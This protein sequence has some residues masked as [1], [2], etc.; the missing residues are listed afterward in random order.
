MRYDDGFVAYLNGREIARTNARIETHTDEIVTSS[1]RCAEE[2]AV[3][4]ARFDVSQ[5][6]TAL[7]SGQNVLAIKVL[8]ARPSSG[9]YLLDPRL[10]IDYQP[11]ARLRKP[12]TIYYTVD[13]PDPRQP[14]G[15]VHPAAQ[16]YLGP[17]EMRRKGTIRARTH[18][19]NVWSALSRGS[20]KDE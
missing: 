13:G 2:S 19:A 10:E 1:T 11:T 3:Q 14:G 4:L 9:D 16:Q 7:R 5:H 6:S 18:E 17:F 8:N 20:A 12:K 15:S